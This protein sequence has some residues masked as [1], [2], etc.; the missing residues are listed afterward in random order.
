MLP[1]K[2][3]KVKLPQLLPV[4]SSV[5]T[6]N[7][8]CFVS[9]LYNKSKL[10]PFNRSGFYYDI[11]YRPA[12]LSRAFLLPLRHERRNQHTQGKPAA[13]RRKGGS[14]KTY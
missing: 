9:R 11:G 12:I 7:F 2:E 14:N 6:H 4:K 3:K 10:L 13:P 8:L 5:K 1:L